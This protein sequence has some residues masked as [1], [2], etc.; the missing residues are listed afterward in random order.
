MKQKSTVSFLCTV[1][2]SCSPHAFAADLPEMGGVPTAAAE[3]VGMSTE[4]LQRLDQVMQA[5]ID[6]KEIAGAVTLVAR[7]GKVVH[8]S[9]LGK[10]DAESGAPMTHDTI[11]R[12]ASMTK[13]I[14][15]AALM[16]MYEEG[17]FQLRDPIS[18]WLPEFADMQV[19]IPAQPQERIAGRYK[20]VPAVR[21]ITVQH[22]L[23]HTAGLP[24]AYRGIMQPE[25][26]EMAA[27]TKPGDTVG[28]ML[29]RLAK[30]P[31][32]F[33][34]GDHWEYGRGTDVVGRLVEVMS[35]QTFDEFLRERIFEPLAMNDTHFYLPA[36]KLDRFAAL[37]HPDADGKME[38]TES[39]TAES[40]YVAEPHVYF[41]GAGGLVST[42]RDYFRF[43][44]MM[45]NGG[46]LD[47][48]RILGR[49]TIELMTSNHTGDKGIWLTGPGYGFGL[50]YA[51]VTDLGPS[52]T[53]RSEGSYYWGGAFGTIFWV[54]PKEE[55]IG[56]LMEQISPYTHINTRPDMATMTYQA[57]VD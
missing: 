36:S 13:P 38:L 15:S 11:F 28:D 51:I 44:Q 55:L 56:I 26:A 3:S 24:N 48:T 30:L 43:H 35:G 17:H 7:Q 16:M 42:A 46:E 29:Q 1:I 25:Y 14:A 39:P 20:T 40:R 31:L 53:P 45:L 2:L 9:A 5:Y 19:A 8:F 4:R 10:R 12:L 37:Y 34:P 52:G 49:K 27:Q 54:D 23:T 6:R 21:P 57:I 41:S 33:Q 50:G 47:G 32:N 18:K 22:V